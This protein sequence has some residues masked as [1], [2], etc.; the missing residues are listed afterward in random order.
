[1]GAK[2]RISEACNIQFYQTLKSN[3]RVKVHQGGT[4]SGKTYAICQ[5]LVYKLT[6]EK[7]PLVISIVRKTLPALKGSAQPIVTGKQIA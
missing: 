4:R 1:M 6:T 2:Q 5:Y 7:D 3:A